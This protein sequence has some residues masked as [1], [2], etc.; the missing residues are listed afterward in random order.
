MNES[1]Q[2]RKTGAIFG[3]D[4]N[5]LVDKQQA[6]KNS[7]P[8]KRQR[9][10]QGEPVV[11]KVELVKNE[12]QLVGD[13]AES[14]AQITESDLSVANDAIDNNAQLGKGD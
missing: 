3:Q 14:G 5:I 8:S 2:Q 9:T 13:Q 1:Q 6:A 4:P 12:Y 10:N 7:K 11:V